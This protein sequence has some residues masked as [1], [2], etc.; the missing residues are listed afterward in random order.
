MDKLLIVDDD[1]SILELLSESA[2][3]L[4]YDAVPVGS[5]TEA[6]GKM[7]SEAGGFPVILTDMMMPGINGLELLR[8]IKKEYPDTLVIM[9][10]ANVSKEMA[11]RSLNEGAFAF[12]IKPVNEDEFKSTLHNAFEKHHQLQENKNS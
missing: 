8:R 7:K 5:A 3:F 2:K 11:T 4:G 10:T 6:V 9:L 1:E 12:L